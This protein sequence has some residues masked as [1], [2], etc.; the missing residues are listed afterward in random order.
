MLMPFADE[1]NEKFTILHIAADGKTDSY[2]LELGGNFPIGPYVCFWEHEQRLHF[3]W[4]KPRGRQIDYAM[5]PLDD[6][7]AGFAS[8]TIYIADDPLIWMDAYLDKSLSATDARSLYLAEEDAVVDPES[9]EPL[10]PKLTLWCVGKM[11]GRLACMAVSVHGTVERRPVFLNTDGISDPRIISSAVTAEN[12]LVFLAVDGG[13]KLY[14]AGTAEKTMRPIEHITGL[15]IRENDFPAL[16]KGGQGALEPWVYLRF[17]TAQKEIDYIKLE[18]AD[19]ADPMEQE[20]QS[21]EFAEDEDED[22]F[23]EQE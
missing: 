8:R 9:L 1:R 12:E 11:P 2:D 18:P 7:A 16:M 17:V 13:G 4:T 22:E 15:Q 10:P 5:L 20:N 3:A 6:L 21:W 14:Y 19:E 23:A